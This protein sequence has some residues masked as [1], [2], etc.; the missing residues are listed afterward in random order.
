MDLAE[1]VVTWSGKM[2]V[3]LD[4][5]RRYLEAI[6]RWHKWIENNKKTDLPYQIMLSRLIR[7]ILDKRA[8]GGA[9]W[10]G[11]PETHEL[12]SHIDWNRLLSFEN[13]VNI[14]R[15]KMEEAALELVQLMGYTIYS[16]STGTKEELRENDFWLELNRLQDETKLDYL[17]HIS[18]QLCLTE[19]GLKFLIMCQTDKEFP[20]QS[21]SGKL[22]PPFHTDHFLMI[23]GQIQDDSLL[24]AKESLRV[25]ASLFSNLVPAIIG[26]GDETKTC[27]IM[28]AFLRK[29][30]T[31]PDDFPTLDPNKPVTS[32]KEELNKIRGEILAE[33][34]NLPDQ[35]NNFERFGGTLG[36]IVGL[37]D[38]YISFIEVVKDP[39]MAN[40]YGFLKGLADTTLNLDTAI[41]AFSKNESKI[42]SDTLARRVNI[43][44][45]AFDVIIASYNFI[46]NSNSADTTET[47][48]YAL[49][50]VGSAFMLGAA[51]ATGG[52]TIIL[53]VAVGIVLSVWG[54]KL[55]SQKTEFLVWFKYNYFSKSWGNSE[56]EGYNEDPAQIPFK[57]FEKVGNKINPNYARQI[58]SLF[59]LFYP[60]KPELNL[61]TIL[62][63]NG[64][65]PENFIW[66][67]EVTVKPVLAYHGST[68]VVKKILPNNQIA[69]LTPFNGQLATPPIYEVKMNN[70]LYG[71]CTPNKPTA[72]DKLTQWKG[73]FSLVDSPGG[74]FSS[75]DWFEIDITLPGEYKLFN[76]DND[77]VGDSI[78]TILRSRVSLGFWY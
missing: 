27:K 33:F 23:P 31:L 64:P 72:T 75:K 21:A 19:V 69:I 9:E 49:K 16:T 68:I 44:L 18:E 51:V 63:R 46:E 28:D 71:T 43:A 42:I 14:E 58:A 65:D 48:G 32:L 30:L 67:L 66:I 3:V 59:S 24:I 61:R 34:P 54:D 41:K 8:K 15:K 12:G 50:L 77:W 37:Y 73:D 26:Q 47:T 70:H 20:L 4:A 17:N 74:V 53:C 78:P 55:I 36:F 40:R 11:V 45:A 57:W 13:G 22:L 7:D 76:N 39:S 2:G 60:S 1:I 29:F 25:I 35:K 62:I 6:D 56:Q 52:L 38:V 10:E 5:H